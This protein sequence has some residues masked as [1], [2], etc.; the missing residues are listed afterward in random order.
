M[1]SAS[2]NDAGIDE[3]KPGDI[4]K[5]V[6]IVQSLPEWFTPDAAIEVREAARNM[7]G[8]TARVGGVV[9][10]FMLLDERECCIEIAW[11]AVEKGFQGRG[12]GTML[13]EAASRYACSKNKP[14]L[15]V[16]TYGGMDYE[17]YLDTLAFYRSR[18]FKLYEVI[19]GYKPFNGQPAAILV[20]KLDCINH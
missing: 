13:M 8:F 10:G 15:T 17:P 2:V 18:G 9:R 19:D 20:K 14:V 3:V 1:S 7:K 5:I 4:D 12:L 6:E 16:K 11:L